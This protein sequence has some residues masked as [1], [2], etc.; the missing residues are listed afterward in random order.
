LIS[1]PVHALVEELIECEE[2]SEVNLKGFA[3][4]VAAFSVVGR[5]IGTHTR[6]TE[7][8]PLKIFT[9]GQFSLLLD[10]KPLTF[11]RKAQKRPLDLLKVLIASG[12]RAVKTS[13]LIESLWPDS[14]GDAAHITFDSTL[15]RLRKLLGIESILVLSEGKL[16][17]DAS[18]CWTD[19][20]A[21]DDL[22]ARID[23]ELHSG[24]AHDKSENNPLAKELLHLC[25]G[26]FLEKDS[27]EPWAV[28]ARDKLKAKFVRAVTLLG[29]TLENRKEWPQAIAL[30]ARA[31]ELDNLTEGIYRRLMICYREQ[32]E[33]AEALNVYRRCRD[34]LSIV[35]NVKPSPETDAIYGSLAQRGGEM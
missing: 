12:R 15:Y 30:Y 14:E 33:P 2:I 16:S 9:F 23:N 34:M 19:V 31:L 11:S 6:E 1:A 8:W 10:G 18:R 4:P 5:K 29:T 3:R 28:Q 35:L 17:L 22:I 20:W 7:V 24:N 26:L 13:T 25:V 21:F 32:G 27:Q